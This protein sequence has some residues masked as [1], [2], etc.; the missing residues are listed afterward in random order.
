MASGLFGWPGG[1]D[2]KAFCVDSSGNVISSGGSVASARSFPVV[3][4]SSSGNLQ[5][6]KGQGVGKV[7]LDGS[8]NVYCQYDVASVNT[9]PTISASLIARDASGNFL[10]GHKHSPAYYEQQV[11]SVHFDGVGDT[12]IAT[13]N[14]KAAAND[15]NFISNPWN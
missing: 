11:S 9:N 1:I 3:K 6:G 12:V 2:V 7:S 14:L 4:Y 8:G 13:G 5:W 10:W 15:V